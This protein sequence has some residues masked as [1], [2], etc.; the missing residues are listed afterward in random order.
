[1]RFLQELT[2]EWR[3]AVAL[4]RRGVNMSRE[5][6]MS[7]HCGSLAEADGNG[8]LGGLLPRPQPLKMRR[9]PSFGEWARGRSFHGV[10]LDQQV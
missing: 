5:Q 3:G 10:G 9:R 6:G 4:Q 1:M 8:N 2:I 7:D